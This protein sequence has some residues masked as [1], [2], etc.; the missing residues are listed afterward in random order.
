[1]LSPWTTT[2]TTVAATTT[3]TKATAAAKPKKNGTHRSN[4]N[5]SN[6]SSNSVVRDASSLGEAWIA[7]FVAR[8]KRSAKKQQQQQATVVLTSPHRV[9]VFPQDAMYVSRPGPTTRFLGT[10]HKV[11]AVVR[12]NCVYALQHDNTK[13]FCGL[14]ESSDKTGKRLPSPAMSLAVSTVLPKVIVYG[15]MQD[16]G[17]FMVI[18]DGNVQTFQTGNNNN[19]KKNKKGSKGQQKRQRQHLCTLLKESV[20][21]RTSTES[22]VPGSPAP[23]TKSTTKKPTSNKKRKHRDEQRDRGGVNSS[24]DVADGT[25]DGHVLYQVFAIPATGTIHIRRH[26][27]LLQQQ[28]QLTQTHEST[29]CIAPAVASS[30]LSSQ[31][32]NDAVSLTALQSQIVGN[33]LVVSGRTEQEQQPFCCTVSLDSARMIGK[34]FWLPLETRSACPLSIQTLAVS[35]LDQIELYSLDSGILIDTVSVDGAVVDTKEWTL[36]S[37]PKTQ[38]L[39]VLSESESKLQLSIATN[40]QPKQQQPHASMS[41]L[42]YQQQQ[43]QNHRNH[44]YESL[45]K[46]LRS[47][48][49]VHHTPSPPA[50]MC[51]LAD[52]IWKRPDTTTLPSDRAAQL[53]E[54]SATLLEPKTKTGLQQAFDECMPTPTALTVPEKDKSKSKHKSVGT[55]KNGLNGVK[56]VNGVHKGRP[57]PGPESPLSAAA[58]ATTTV[59]PQHFVDGA[60]S[61]ILSMLLLPKSENAAMEKR[62]D[63]NRSE[64]RVLLQHLAQSGQLSARRHLENS[65]PSILRA[66]DTSAAVFLDTV[67][68]Y[69]SD[70]TEKHLV[71]IIRFIM[72]G[73]SPDAVAKLFLETATAAATTTTTTRKASSFTAAAS[74]LKVP[75]PGK[76]AAQAF[77]DARQSMV[78]EGSALERKSAAL[79]RYG[80]QYVVQNAVEYSSCNETLLR[81]AF[82]QHLQPEE[83]T[84]LLRTLLHLPNPDKNWCGWVYALCQA[85]RDTLSVTP[86]QQKKTKANDGTGPSSKASSPSPSLLQHV[87]HRIRD[88]SSLVMTLQSLS[89]AF[90]QGPVF[91][92]QQRVSTTIKSSTHTSA[93]ATRAA[94]EATAISG[95]TR[96]VS[97]SS[98]RTKLAGYSV[99]R[100]AF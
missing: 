46:R 29:I 66:M 60:V 26:S 67:L 100:L 98:P 56:H 57:G 22:S 92:T 95:P 21:I 44:P 81:H 55:T 59:I 78:V 88:E 73:A 65:L 77:L 42:P 89:S 27:V 35:V 63:A 47:S 70:V 41:V 75:H 18:D 10:K 83:A 17:F 64:A 62:M 74:L 61:V 72:I 9:S 93:T 94:T 76:A 91:A 7:S 71:T 36:L 45:A 32:K 79:L 19:K 82:A 85:H 11:P 43:Q 96:T 86:F 20:S 14:S 97:S 80:I 13:L 4:T 23:T 1:M 12:N 24:Q 8:D 99:E 6:S 5:G 16:E 30:L 51:N 84:L 50:R 15:T 33:T 68:Q 40:T 54:K 87:L 53:R 48:L 69:C 31:A 3:A 49:A 58:T 52:A 90:P 2:T 25:Q 37:D 34:P 38:R 28:A 39:A